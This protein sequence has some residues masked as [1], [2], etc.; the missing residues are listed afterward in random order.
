[1]LSQTVELF[2]CQIGLAKLAA[3]FLSFVFSILC[4]I[5][6]EITFAHSHG[7][8]QTQASSLRSGVQ[9]SVSKRD[10]L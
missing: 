9:R 10:R 5:S 8:G 2:L 7:P 4:P 3:L 1:V 6:T